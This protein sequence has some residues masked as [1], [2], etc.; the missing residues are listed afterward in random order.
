M[1]AGAAGRRYASMRSVSLP[2]LFTPAQAR[3]IERHRVARLATAGPDGRPHV[4]P[5]CYAFDGQ[6]LYTP[7][8]EKPKRAAAVRLQRVRNVQANPQAALV[9]DDYSDDWSRLAYVLVRGRAEMLPEGRAQ[10]EALRLLR[11]RYPQY[12]AMALEERP[13]LVISPERVV[14]WGK[15]E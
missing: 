1:P 15:V 11:E 5:I 7:I 6:R 4:V 3:F 9:V 2:S 14:S 8:D 13:L 12:Q 10:P